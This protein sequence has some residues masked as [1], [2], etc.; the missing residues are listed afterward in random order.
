MWELKK[1]WTALTQNCDYLE[2]APHS[3]HVKSQSCVHYLPPLEIV[4]MAI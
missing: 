1:L 4:D 3:P 2:N